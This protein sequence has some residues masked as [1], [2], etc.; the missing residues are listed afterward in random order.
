MR[1]KGQVTP[2]MID[3][4][5]PHQVEILSDDNLGPRLPTMHEFCRNMDVKTHGLGKRRI[6]IGRD[7]MRWCFKTPT[8]A[9][10]FL[11]RFGGERFTIATRER[12]PASPARRWR[13]PT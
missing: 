6:E 9:D 12:K 10:T 8:D 7:G 3:R 11:A 1:Y 2:K 4:D 5:Y 13:R